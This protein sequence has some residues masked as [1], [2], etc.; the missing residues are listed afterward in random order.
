MNKVM[1]AMRVVGFRKHTSADRRSCVRAG[2]SVT[3]SLRA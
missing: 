1:R 2:S 3:D